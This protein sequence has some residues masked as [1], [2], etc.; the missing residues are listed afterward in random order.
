MKLSDLLQYNDIL[1]QC[2]ND[3]DADA[4]ASG[5][6]VYT[7]LKEQGKSVRFVYSGDRLIQ[8]SNL[9]LLVQTF[10]IPIEHVPEAGTAGLLLTVDCQPGQGNVSE[11]TGGSTA[12]IDHHQVADPRALPELREIHSNYGSCATIVW[13]LLQEAGYEV[14]GNRDL[15]T[16]LYYG[17]YT[18]TNKLQE[19][20]HPMDKDMRDSLKIDKS[21][22]F[23][24]QNAN[25]SL[26]ELGIAGKALT[27]YDYHVEGRFAIVKAKPCD[28]N[29]LGVI[30]DMLVEVDVIDSCIAYCMLSGNVKLSIRSCVREIRADELA[31]YLA[32]G[33][34][35]G[36]GHARKAGGF[37]Y[38]DRV[39]DEYRK[40]YGDPEKAED[41]V[42]EILCG[43]METY[44]RSVEIL[45]TAV[46]APDFS[47]AGLYRKRS[48]LIGYVPTQEVFA[49]GTELLVRMLEGDFQVV[50]DEK[51]YLMIGVDN[52]V[53][54]NGADTFRENYETAQEPWQ[55]EGEYA[56]TVC[57]VVTGE[58]KSLVPYVRSCRSRD[59]S[60]V[61]AKRLTRRMKLFTRWD[62][63]NYMLGLEGDW[64]VCRENAS[65][66]A[67][68]VKKDIF[69]R[70]YEGMAADAEQNL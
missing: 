46:D 69:P 50:S 38:G 57:D 42:H 45:D 24:F 51:T 28:P 10:S 60:T 61:L 35:N 67:Y 64:L 7:Y 40:R 16:A 48:V 58:R 41:P 68:I 34:G 30:S 49:P 63:E 62:R 70:L 21:Q 59:T 6:G 1:I 44:C 17:L 23:R 4:I 2:H 8:K 33:L 55:F 36:G 56:P 43:R 22:I 53:Y 18:D 66:D 20:S 26:E 32:E 3:P 19:I 39:R 54:P 14:N 31:A 29:I 37:L 9:L 65:D 12:V 52:E 25:L 13:K 47:D 15:A 5:F 11:L 27:D